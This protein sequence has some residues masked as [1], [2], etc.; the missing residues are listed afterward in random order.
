[1]KP[2][3]T[4]IG[5]VL[6]VHLLTS[7][8][9]VDKVTFC[10]SLISCCFC[11]LEYLAFVMFIILWWKDLFGLEF[12]EDVMGFNYLIVTKEW[13]FLAFKDFFTLEESLLTPH[14]VERWSH[15]GDHTN[16]FWAMPLRTRKRYVG[17]HLKRHQ[18]NI[19]T[20]RNHSV[21]R[22]NTP[23]LTMEYTGFPFPEG[24]QSYVTGECFHK[25]LRLF[26]K[27]FELESHIQVSI[28]LYQSY[29]FQ[30]KLKINIHTIAL[31]N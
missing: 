8:Y 26:T 14:S 4:Y 29:L 31:L 28:R 15:A 11:C 23:R 6:L 3:A 13:W 9:C 12:G 2:Q 30:E 24:T 16:V 10:C 18:V 27:Q 17:S 20:V 21:C 7:S 19:F 1:M 22:I 25:Y 5:P